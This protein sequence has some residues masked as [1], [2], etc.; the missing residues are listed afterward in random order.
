[1]KRKKKK[2]NFFDSAWKKIVWLATGIFA[3]IQVLNAIFGTS[4]D[5][6]S[7]FEHI[8]KTDVCNKSMLF[9]N[10]DTQKV[11]IIIA[12]FKNLK[13]SNQDVATIIRNGILEK[14]KNSMNQKI[15]ILKECVVD[16]SIKATEILNFHNADLVIWGEYAEFANSDSSLYKIHFKT[17]ESDWLPNKSNYLSDS[18]SKLHF[19]TLLN[20]EFSGSFDFIITYVSAYL[21]FISGDSQNAFKLFKTL[22]YNGDLCD[23]QTLTGV[24]FTGIECDEHAEVVKILAKSAIK[25]KNLDT[26]CYTN[27]YLATLLSEAEVHKDAFLLAE[28]CI[29]YPAQKIKND[30]NL[31]LSIH[32]IAFASALQLYDVEKSCFYFN[33]CKGIYSEN[34]NKLDNSVRI[35]ATNLLSTDLPFCK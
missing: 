9:Q 10:S 15:E 17:I 4:S 25:C 21:S 18:Y 29:N 20:G 14:I 30:P 26:Y 7:T 22:Y 34:A 16:D 12:Q 28:N 6:I 11:K 24:Y 35:A 3:I 31:W 33:S 32:I 27:F 5:A 23:Y 19:A 2:Y 8:Y 13:G 1:M